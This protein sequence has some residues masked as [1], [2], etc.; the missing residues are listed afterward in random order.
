MRGRG[1]PKGK[2]TRQLLWGEGTTLY[3]GGGCTS[4]YVLKFIEPE[5][6]TK[7]VYFTV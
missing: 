4:L 3:P 2:G 7:E 1:A 5:A 6:K